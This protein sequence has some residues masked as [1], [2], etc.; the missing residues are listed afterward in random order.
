MQCLG[1]CQIEVEKS[2]NNK[3]CLNIWKRF[4]NKSLPCLCLVLDWR[5]MIWTKDTG[6]VHFILSSVIDH[7]PLGPIKTEKNKTKD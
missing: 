4:D 1:K 2:N 6:I 7:F 3:N 5:R